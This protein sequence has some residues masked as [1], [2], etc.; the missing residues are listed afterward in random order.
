[1]ERGNGDVGEG[2]KENERTDGLT[3]SEREE[4]KGR[5]HSMPASHGWWGTGDTCPECK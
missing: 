4:R 2:E 5:Q 3:A 1:M